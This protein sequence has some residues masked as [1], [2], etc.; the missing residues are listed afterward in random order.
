MCQLTP[1]R[2]TFTPRQSR[3][4]SHKAAPLTSLAMP[5]RITPHLPHTPISCFAPLAARA[6]QSTSTPTSAQS[7]AAARTAQLVPA[8]RSHVAQDASAGP[9]KRRDDAGALPNQRLVAPSHVRSL[10]RP[11]PQQRGVSHWRAVHSPRYSRPPSSSSARTTYT[12]RTA[13]GRT[14]CGR[15]QRARMRWRLQ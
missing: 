12:Q 1:P 9:S 7:A 14:V 3:Q 13:H 15:Q 11:A 8:Q 2:S 6:S 10:A 5:T 4:Q